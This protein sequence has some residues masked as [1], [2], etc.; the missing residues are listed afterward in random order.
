MA[1]KREPKKETSSKSRS[2]EIGGIDKITQIIP[3]KT[4]EYTVGDCYI[5]FSNEVRDAISDGYIRD[6]RVT[7]MKPQESEETNATKQNRQT[8]KGTR[9]VDLKLKAFN[10]Y[11]ITYRIKGDNVYNM[12]F[13]KHSKKGSW[14]CYDSKEAATVIPKGKRMGFGESYRDIGDP[15]YAKFSYY[16]MAEAIRILDTC[17]DIDLFKKPLRDL[18]V[19]ICEPLRFEDIRDQASQCMI[20]RHRVVVVSD[21]WSNWINKIGRAHV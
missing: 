12:G 2:S 11:G 15:M 19:I 5:T 17:E 1:P 3:Y 18:C 13:E 20:D 7:V 10:K 4:I 9:V 6:K 8:P 16:A 14:Y 21:K